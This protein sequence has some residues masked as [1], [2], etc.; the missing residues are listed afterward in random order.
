MSDHTGLPPMN[1]RSKL[2]IAGLGD[3]DVLYRLALTTLLTWQSFPMAVPEHVIQKV[4]VH[5]IL[6]TGFSRKP[7]EPVTRKITVDMEPMPEEAKLEFA[8]LD[9]ETVLMDSVGLIIHMLMHHIE[10]PLTLGSTAAMF[11]HSFLELGFRR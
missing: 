5:S 11:T 10:E 7:G 9:D 4:M 3:E 2:Q 6:E 1:E 8:G